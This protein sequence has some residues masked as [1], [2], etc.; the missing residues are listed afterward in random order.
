MGIVN[1]GL[2]GGMGYW[3]YQNRNLP[4]DRRNVSAA[5][6]GTLALFGVEG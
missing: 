6:A 4:W 2:L 1:V 3:A 5:V